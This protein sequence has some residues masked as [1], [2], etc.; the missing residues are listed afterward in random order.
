MIDRNLVKRIAGAL[1]TD[2]GLVEKDWHVVRAIAILASL[3]QAGGTLVFSGG[4]SLSKGWGLIKRFSED[5]DFMLAMPETGTRSQGRRARKAYREKA[6]VAL[7]GS[8]FEL[9]GKPLVGNE[10]QFFAADLGYSSDF[11]ARPGI[12]PY[13]R[14]EVSFYSTALKPI[15][16][17][18]QSLIAKAQGEGPEVANFPCVDPIETAADKL[19]TLAWRVCARQ[20]GSENDD[21]RIVRHLYDL[22]ALES[23]VA[24]DSGFAEL[25]QQTVEEDTGRGGE[26]VPKN[27]KER[28]AVMFE[29]LQDDKEWASEYET[30]V[31]QASFAQHGERISFS[32]ALGATGRLI[33]VVYRDQKGHPDDR[34]V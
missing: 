9:A 6:L 27:P 21:P 17:P 23:Y 4:T 16:R 24:K 30:F 7:T 26:G 18:I 14:I 1:A 3:D 32:K 2:E 20:R 15:E 19:S 31:L 29:K 33:A 34:T 28:F 8:G 25:V 10:S 22:A 13:V 5:I 12:R 11:P